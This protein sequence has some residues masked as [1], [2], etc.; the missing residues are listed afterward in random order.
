M[1]FF[2]ALF[3]LSFFLL[4][5]AL[6]GIRKQK[7]LIDCTPSLSCAWPFLVPPECDDG[8][9][10]PVLLGRGCLNGI[11]ISYQLRL[12]AVVSGTVHHEDVREIVCQQLTRVSDI[13]GRFCRKLKNSTRETVWSPSYRNKYINPQEYRYNNYTLFYTTG[14]AIL[15]LFV[16]LLISRDLMQRY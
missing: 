11:Q 15:G 13:D 14:R 5:N 8:E 12:H 4:M 16:L 1:F 3:L 2:F 7:K 10:R 6:I 9:C